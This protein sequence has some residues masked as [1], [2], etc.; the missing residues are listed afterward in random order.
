MSGQQAIDDLRAKQGLADSIDPDF[1]ADTLQ[2]VYDDVTSVQASAAK[3]TTYYNWR[4][5]VTA[6]PPNSGEIKIVGTSLYISS[7]LGNG[8]SYQNVIEAFLRGDEFQ[9]VEAFPGVGTV[10]YKTYRVT[11][12]PTNNT[13]WFEVPIEE[14]SAA[15]SFTDEEPVKAAPF[16]FANRS[17]LDNLYYSV[18]GLTQTDQ[19]YDTNPQT[20]LNETFNVA[21]SQVEVELSFTSSNTSSFRSTVLELF[22][23]ASAVARSEIEPSDTSDKIFQMVVDR[24]SLTANSNHTLEVKIGRTGPAFGAGFAQVTDLKVKVSEW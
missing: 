11:G 1:H 15:G 17:N 2:A 3:S 9:I 24:K 13:T 21:Y 20:L 5:D 18:P 19:S 23:D 6:T 7:G 16:E 4:T 14:L 22:I 12:A 8:V 10:A